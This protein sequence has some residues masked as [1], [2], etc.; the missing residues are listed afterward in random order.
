[1]KRYRLT[2]AD[3]RD[4]LSETPG[5]LGGHRG[6]GVYGRSIARRRCAHW[7]AATPTAAT[8][9]SLP[10]SRPPSQ[11]AFGRARGACRRSIRCGRRKPEGY[12]VPQ[13]WELD[14]GRTRPYCASPIRLAGGL[15]KDHA[16]DVHK[17]TLPRPRFSQPT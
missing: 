2:G 8:A 5:T 10:T 3:G 6:T 15:S 14:C 17:H 13:R 9:S 1:M 16:I 12:D 7:R 4:F 11:R